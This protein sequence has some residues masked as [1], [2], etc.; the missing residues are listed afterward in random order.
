MQPAKQAANDMSLV[1]FADV[2]PGREILSGGWEESAPLYRALLL[3]HL[4]YSPFS[5]GHPIT[6]KVAVKWERAMGTAMKMV[7]GPERLTIRKELNQ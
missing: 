7:E 4:I 2:S 6:R 3:S 5:S 1:S